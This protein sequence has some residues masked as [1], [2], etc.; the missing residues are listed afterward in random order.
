MGLGGSLEWHRGTT[1][2][3]LE[4]EGEEQSLNSEGLGGG[5]GGGGVGVGGRLGFL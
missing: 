5:S 2:E 3:D 4:T 1:L